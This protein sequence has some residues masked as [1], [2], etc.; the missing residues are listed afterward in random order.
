MLQISVLAGWDVARIVAKKTQNKLEIE[1]E[2]I[3]ISNL[4]YLK[5]FYSL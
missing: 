5:N 4:D 3:L 2:D 1:T